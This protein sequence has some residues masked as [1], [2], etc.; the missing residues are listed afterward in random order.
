M[1]KLVSL[2]AIIFLLCSCVKTPI[3]TNE[4]Y[5]ILKSNYPIVNIN[6]KEI[7]PVY[8]HNIKAGKNTVI[9][10]YHSYQVD[11]FCSFSWLVKSATNYEV[12]DQNQKY[13]LTL[14]RWV[15][16]NSLWASRLDPVNPTECIKVNKE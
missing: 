13:P 11:Y 4:N 16:T 12:T 9:I 14:Y 10:V 6:G 15:K 1:K 7:T 3:Y 8:S 5:A 2:L